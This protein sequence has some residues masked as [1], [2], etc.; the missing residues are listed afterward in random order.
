MH[1]SRC[2][3]DLCACP[4]LQKCTCFIDEILSFSIIKKHC[5]LLVNLEVDGCPSKENLF[6]QSL[7]E[8]VAEVTQGVT[9]FL[10]IKV[11]HV[12]CHTNLNKLKIA[13]I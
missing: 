3:N 1:S 2:Y 12:K 6:G 9:R 10:L 4:C 11:A 7:K 13:L 5:T 8:N